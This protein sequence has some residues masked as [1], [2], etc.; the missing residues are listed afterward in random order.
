MSLGLYWEEQMTCSWKD[1]KLLNGWSYT[2]YLG[3]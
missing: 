2:I 3:G 1:S